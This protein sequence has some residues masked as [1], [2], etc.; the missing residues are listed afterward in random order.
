MLMAAASA[1]CLLRY[2]AKK[3]RRSMTPAGLVHKGALR[4]FP[5]L[6]YVPGEIRSVF[7][8][9]ERQGSGERAGYIDDKGPFPG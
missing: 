9:R 2:S 1:L 7:P 5:A 6:R 4:A 8:K 3:A